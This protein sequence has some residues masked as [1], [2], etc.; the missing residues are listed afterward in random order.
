MLLDAATLFRLLCIH[1]KD[2]APEGV[3]DPE[4]FAPGLSLDLG[5]RIALNQHNTALDLIVHGVV[6]PADFENI[7][8]LACA[9]CGCLAP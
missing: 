3:A 6:Q 2:N 4:Y 5:R 9:F 7:I 8:C 1:T